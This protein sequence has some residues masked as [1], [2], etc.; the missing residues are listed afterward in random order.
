VVLKKLI[1]LSLSFY[2]I[3]SAALASDKM[4]SRAD[5]ITLPAACPVI[6]V[7]ARYAG[8]NNFLGEVVRGYLA[9]IAILEK[10]AANKLCQAANELFKSRGL[11]FKVFDAY[12]PT[13]AVDH[14]MQWA[15]T[16]E[17]NLAIKQQYYPKLERNQLI[18]LGYIAAV[19]G[20][21]RGSTVDLTLYDPKTHTELDMGGSFD[22]FDEVSHTDHST[23]S[24]LARKN[25]QLLLQVMQTAGFKNYAK[26]W[27]HFTL[28]QEKF[29][30]QYFNFLVK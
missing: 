22:F 18:P 8:V 2:A 26:E 19:S 30:D 1:N 29:P 7:D 13:Q 16:P 3:T 17:N 27:W 5:F 20:H 23:I 9:P 15:S 12:R 6:V 11:T 21:S 14:F 10:N 28:N 25:R 24:E 4:D